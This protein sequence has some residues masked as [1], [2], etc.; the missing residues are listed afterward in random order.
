MMDNVTVAPPINTALVEDGEGLGGVLEESAGA[1]EAQTEAEAE[2]PREEALKATIY[3]GPSL[4]RIVQH[5]TIFA[6]G[7]VPG[8]LEAKVK[9]VPAIRGLI[10]PFG[11]CAQVAKAITLPDGRYRM[12]YDMVQGTAVTR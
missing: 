8:I 3:M 5:G 2:A 1:D 10:V 9:E 12:L 6:D 4:D 11:Q 7:T